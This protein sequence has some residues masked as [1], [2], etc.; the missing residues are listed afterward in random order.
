M[1]RLIHP[2]SF[3]LIFL[4]VA[5]GTFLSHDTT[6]KRSLR[7]C[8]TFYQRPLTEEDFISKNNT[9]MGKAKY[10][11]SSG[12]IT[13][14][15]QRI[16]ENETCSDCDTQH[17]NCQFCISRLQ[18]NKSRPSFEELKTKLIP[19]QKYIIGDSWYSYVEE[20]PVPTKCLLYRGASHTEYVSCNKNFSD[21]CSDSDV[22]SYKAIV[23][24]EEN[25]DEGNTT[26]TVY[27]C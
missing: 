14:Q 12:V 16:E 13:L 3:K 22:S 11:I 21:G 7:V 27:I 6:W 26:Y 4:V 18:L 10:V 1:T 9:W 8:D 5:R 24:F 25:N 2:D 17:K 23:Y 19:G 15:I 20:I